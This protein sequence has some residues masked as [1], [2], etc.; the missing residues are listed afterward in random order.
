M[1]SLHRTVVS[2]LA[3]ACV[4]LTPVFA[5]EEGNE[6]TADMQ[7]LREA[8]QKK[9]GEFPSV[10]VNTDLKTVSFQ[11]L[12]LSKTLTIVAGKNY[13]AFRFKTPDKPGQFIW[14]CVEPMG[15]CQWYIVPTRGRMHGFT[16]FE[17]RVLQADVQNVGTTGLCLLLQR[18]PAENFK[19][20]S[21]YIIWFSFADKVS[22]KITMSVN[23]L[24][25]E[26]LE[27]RKVF[28]VLYQ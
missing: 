23:M 17:K 14:S 27:Y 22:P 5:Q 9:A 24:T 19:G 28:S 18:L 10:A 8:L 26:N 1:R 15:T 21:E 6:E 20:N 16:Q 25:G 12:D 7:M 4:F 11:T 3:I 2:A 13:Y